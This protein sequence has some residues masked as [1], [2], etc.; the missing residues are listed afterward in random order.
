MRRLLAVRRSDSDRATTA[1][2]RRNPPPRASDTVKPPEEGLGAAIGTAIASSTGTT[3]GAFVGLGVA[4]PLG[5]GLGALLGGVSTALVKHGGTRALRHLKARRDARNGPP[6][7]T[8]SGGSIEDIKRDL[9][10]AQDKAQ[11]GIEKYKSARSLIDSAKVVLTELMDGST[12]PDADD[13]L[14]HLDLA[15]GELGS[16]IAGSESGRDG[17]GKFANQL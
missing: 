4:G 1:A 16:V 14:L 17:F 15:L 2:R 11:A 8:A 6:P 7:P 3:V 12:H 9:A 13:A 5:L 10:I